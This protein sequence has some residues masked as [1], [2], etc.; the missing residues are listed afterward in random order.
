MIYLQ[1][2]LVGLA[3]FGLMAGCLYVMALAKRRQEA[4]KRSK[5]GFMGM[6][7]TNNARKEAI[8]SVRMF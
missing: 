6:A 5:R 8:R 3:W 2:I 7:T 1:S 4:A